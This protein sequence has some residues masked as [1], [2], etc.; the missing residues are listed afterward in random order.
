MSRRLHV[1][2][3]GAGVAALEA[4]LALRV[5]A[6][7]LVTVELIAPETAFTYRPLAVAEPFQAVEGGRFPL[8]QLVR[9]AGATLR[10]GRVAA[11]DPE[12][13]T[14][15]L[16][17]GQEL[18]YDALLLALGARPREAVPGAITAAVSRTRRRS[19]R[20]STEP[21]PAQCGASCS[22]LLPR[23]RGHCR[24]TSWRS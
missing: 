17:S 18:A 3:A 22:P 11:V 14:V 6:D 5:L 10:E 9:A 13:K 19:P 4:A 16:A 7:E 12:R 2:I 20:C 23:S 1:V 15:E 24:S 21:A 8:G